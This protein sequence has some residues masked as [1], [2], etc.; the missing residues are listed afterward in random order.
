MNHK[1]T[2]K[3]GYPWSVSHYKESHQYLG[4]DTSAIEIRF[5]M[6]ESLLTVAVVLIIP[7]SLTGRDPSPKS[8]S[9]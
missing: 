2:V 9:S 1:L 5:K 7:K 3:L 8:L 4:G 6:I